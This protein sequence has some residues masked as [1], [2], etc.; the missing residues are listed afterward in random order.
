MKKMKNVLEWIGIVVM[1]AIPIV[2]FVIVPVYFTFRSY[3]MWKENIP[4]Y[5]VVITIMCIGGRL[6]YIKREKS[7]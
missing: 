6:Y 5:I 2:V 3:W 4:F 7:H 1:I